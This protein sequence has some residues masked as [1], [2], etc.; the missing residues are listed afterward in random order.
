[1]KRQINPS[2]PQELNLG[3]L[4]SVLSQEALFKLI[5]E[6]ND[7]SYKDRK[8]VLPSLRTCEKVFAHQMWSRI[9]AGL[10]TWEQVKKRYRKQFGSMT[11]IG[12]RKDMVI[13]LYNQR[14]KE[15]A[16]ERS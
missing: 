10:T 9:L 2:W 7:K 11:K 6:Y 13:K 16:R 3:V 1:M 4:E 5:W 8:I 12:I 14:E 15:I